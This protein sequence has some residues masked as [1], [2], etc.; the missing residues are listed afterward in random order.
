MKVYLYSRVSTS[1]QTLKQQERTAYSWLSAHN[2]KVDE[3]VSDEGVSG[4]VSYKE[5]N[6]G[7]ILIPK[8]QESD[9]L[10]VSEISRLGRSMADLNTLINSELKDRKIRLV[11]VSMS[12]D[13]NC[14]KLTAIDQMILNNF[15]FA[16]QLEKELIQDRTTSALQT[17]KDL[18]KSQGYYINKKGERVTG[19]GAASE[20]YH[21]SDSSIAQSTKKAGNTRNTNTIKSAEFQSFCRILK[22]VFKPLQER[23][24]L[25][26]AN[27]DLFMLSWDGMRTELLNSITRSDLLAVL[28]Q[29]KDAKSDNAELFKQYDMNTIELNQIRAKIGNTF[30]T[31]R[32]YIINNK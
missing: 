25:L 2:M 19:L 1:E 8:L 11:I 17:R 5:R 6:L 20:S 22:R 31:I 15:A 24:D 28:Q 18:I 9:V 27:D 21:K 7:K 16:A 26:Q 10:I 13:L 29:M 23:T 30:N 14:Y 3:V 12:I 4:G 32:T